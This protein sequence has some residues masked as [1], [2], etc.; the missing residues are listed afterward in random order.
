MIVWGGI[1]Q[2]CP[3]IS[4]CGDG[5]SYDPG[6]DTWAPLPSLGAP[7]AR[8][9]H[10]AVWASDRMVVW[11]GAVDTVNHDYTTASGAVFDPTGNVW[12]ATDLPA[13]PAGRELHTAIWTG[14]EMIVWG[15]QAAPAGVF[16]VFGDGGRLAMPSGTWSAVNMTNSPVPRTWHTAVWTGSRMLVWGGVS[17]IDVELAD[18]GSYDPAT[19][20]WSPISGLGAPAPRHAATAVWTGTEMAIWGGLGCGGSYCGDGALYDPATDRW[21][22]IATSGAPAARAGPSGLWTGDALIVWGGGARSAVGNG[23][24]YRPD[25]GVWAATGSLVGFSPR[26]NH[27]AVW[28]GTAMLIWGG[29]AGD[30]SLPLGD[31]AAYTP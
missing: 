13:A 1:S 14:K 26:S 11:G 7:T 2:R 10:T 8:K 15:G 27:S 29:R 25:A 31:G 23:G 24:V 20:S 19:D 17:A 28:A 4:L 12:T 6:A 16:I 21:R 3:P 22:P 9:M 5:F 30:P 18:G